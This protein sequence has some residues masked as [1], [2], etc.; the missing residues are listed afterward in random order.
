VAGGITTI[1]DI[2]LLKE[3]GAHAIVLG[4]A[5]YSGRLNLIEAM[6]AAR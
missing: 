4:S 2:R 6:E 5:L 3:I 1:K